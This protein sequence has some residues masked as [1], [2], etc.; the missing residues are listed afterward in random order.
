MAVIIIPWFA[1]FRDLQSELSEYY[2]STGERLQFS[3]AIG[4]LRRKGRLVPQPVGWEPA[5]PLF[6]DKDLF[7]QYVDSLYF[8]VPPDLSANER[9][10][11]KDSGIF[12]YMNDVF[13][14]RHPRY[15]RPLPHS[16]DFLEIEC[17]ITGSCRLFFEDT[18]LSLPQGTVCIV[19]PGSKHDVEVPDDS[20]VY[21][22]ML[23]RSTFET[24]FFSLL[25]RNDALSLFFRANLNED[26]GPNYLM[27]HAAGTPE[28]ERAIRR[29]MYECFRNDTYSNTCAISYVHLLFAYLLRAAG[30]SPNFYRYQAGADFSQILHAIRHHYQ[31]LTLTELAEQ[32][33]YSRPHLC[34]LIRQNTGMSFTEL[35]KQIR[36]SRAEEYLMNTDLPVFEIAEIVGYHSADHFARVFRGS[37]SCSPQEYRR[38]HS[39]DRENFFPFETQK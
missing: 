10:E 11:E 15:T 12:P 14:F 4:S 31:T 5:D 34:T 24:T 28:I 13:V 16:H 32:F 19:A 39:R 26:Q 36:M 8:P 21:C 7:E 29:A 38:T 27:F 9:V 23:R 18:V 37:F 6:M 25:S 35:I 20:T 33:H 30:D 1:S 22:L 3:E 17:V 2:R